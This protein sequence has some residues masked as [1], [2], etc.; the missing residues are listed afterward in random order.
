MILTN[1][2][3]FAWFEEIFGYIREEANIPLEII[4]N[5]EHEDARLPDGKAGIN[6]YIS[7]IGPLGGQG[8]NKRVKVDIS[9]SERTCIC[10]FMAK[11]DTKLFRSGRT[12]TTMLSIGGSFSGKI[13]V[14][15]AAYA[16]T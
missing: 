13:T 9:R 6:F 5:I 2:Q 7:Y 11:Y 10:S 8:N 3:I 15:D 12:Q 1:E 16:S 14:S 4:D